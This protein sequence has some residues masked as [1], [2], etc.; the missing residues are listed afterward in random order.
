MFVPSLR[1]PPNVSV[2]YVDLSKA[3]Y[4]VI[5]GSTAAG[6]ANVNAINQAILDY[7]GTWA[8]L[9]LPYGTTYV[10]KV[11]TNWSILFGSTASK[12]HFKGQG[13]KGTRLVQN[14]VG[15]GNDW[16]FIHIDRAKDITISDMMIEAGEIVCSSEG[17]HDHLIQLS[18][19]GPGA[20]D[21][22]ERVTLQDLHFGKTTSDAIFIYGD[23]RAVYDTVI[24]N[25]TMELQGQVVPNWTPSTAYPLNAY[26]TNG[27]E[28][29]YICTTA[30]TSGTIGPNGA[31]VVADMVVTVDPATDIFSKA[32]AHTLFTSDGPFQ[33]T[34]TGVLPGGITAGLDYYIIKMADLTYKIASTY[35]ASVGLVA[36]DITSAGTGTLTMS[37][38]PTT[39]RATGI[40][41][42]GGGTAIWKY[43]TYRQGARTG[44]TL[45][46]GYDNV[47]VSNLMIRGAQNSLI[48]NEATNTGIMR[49]LYLTNVWLDNSQGR[50]S[51]AM[52]YSGS[53]AGADPMDFCGIDGLHVYAGRLHITASENCYLNN[54]IARMDTPTLTDSTL[55]L[56]EVRGISKN[57]TISNLKAYRGAGA[58]AGVVL[59]IQGSTSGPS[60]GLDSVN[61]INAQI[62]Q[63]TNADPVLVDA[64]SDCW[65]SGTKI[66]YT[67]AYN[68]V[69]R[70]IKMTATVGNS[71]R[72]RFDNTTIDCPAGA[73]PHA[74]SFEARALVSSPFTAWSMTDISVNG[75][76]S[77]GPS[78]AVLFSKTAACPFDPSPM[79]HNVNPGG[80][81]LFTAEDH[82]GAPT[83]DKV[84]PCTAGSK[85]PGGGMQL[86]GY[87]APDANVSAPP[88]S[89]Y[90]LLA[91]TASGASV[92]YYKVQGLNNYGWALITKGAASVTVLERPLTAGE[93]TTFKD[94]NA[95]TGIP[96]PTRSWGGQVASGNLTP[97]IGTLDLVAAGA[98][99]YSNAI[100]GYSDVAV[101]IPDGGAS[102]GFQT[103]DASLA[104]PAT[105]SSFMMVVGKITGTPAAGRGL[106]NIS[107]QSQ[108]RTTVT[109]AIR[110]LIGGTDSVVSGALDTNVHC[111]FMG[112]NET[113]NTV[114]AG[115]EDA[116]LEPAYVG[117][118]SASKRLA[119]GGFDATSQGM[120]VLAVYQWEGADAELMT[121]AN[122]KLLLTA[123]NAGVAW[124]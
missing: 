89:R 71:N 61:V 110:V 38:T 96:T 97:S 81:T 2:P 51:V 88:G 98:V 75:L 102:T 112:N 40:V 69:R 92:P 57:L 17:Q 70:G 106:M 66:R 111:Y 15:T 119:V 87:I 31:L 65:F 5:A 59:D 56:V 37:D 52:S 83:T 35:N 19:L 14:G 21:R 100:S 49:G 45:Q 79:I 34:T 11:A 29:S 91:A 90:E 60:Y 84:F 103:T 73:I 99:T 43:A 82:L 53:N 64:M 26:V 114:M 78:N 50:T 63:E 62:V 85:G 104:S 46:R 115:T 124:I 86:A 58:G 48:D 94:A 7:T 6:I 123:M 16:H 22:T 121:R 47:R 9:A 68:A 93:W 117:P 4:N 23:T 13:T 120:Q 122:V 18:N 36:I 10:D 105:V 33:F 24:S 95:I 54:I 72:P 67:G 118:S 42:Q 41:D 39:R 1:P 108:L 107:D 12:L 101:G 44:L 109:P 20:G 28:F 8:T 3:P 80:G 113:A 32:T 74:I 30:G 55:P 77:N 76:T 27:G 25:I 116:I